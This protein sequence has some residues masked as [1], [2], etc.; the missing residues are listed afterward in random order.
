MNPETEY[1]LAG[2]ADALEIVKKY[3]NEYVVGDCYYIIM[4]PPRYQVGNRVFKMQLY[5]ITGKNNRKYYCFSTS[6]N[7][8]FPGNDLTLSSLSSLKMRVYK[9]KEEAERNK[10]SITIK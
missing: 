3:Q 4:P 5:K 2:L 8:K 6:I 7:S 1:Y 10:D 9:T